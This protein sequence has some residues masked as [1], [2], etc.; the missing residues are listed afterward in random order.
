MIILT[1]ETVF[2]KQKGK[3]MKFTP[4]GTTA[5]VKHPFPCNAFLPTEYLPVEYL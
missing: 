3:L 2:Q 4:D 1:K 5:A